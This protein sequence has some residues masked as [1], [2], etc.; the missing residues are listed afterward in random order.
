MSW[1]ERVIAEWDASGEMSANQIAKGSDI[2]SRLVASL[3]R[4]RWDLFWTQ[5]F[6]VP[7]PNAWAVRNLWCRALTEVSPNLSGSSHS[8]AGSC[9]SSHV[10][11]ALYALEPHN[12]YPSLHVHSLLSLKRPISVTSFRH[13]W[14]SWKNWSWATM[15]KALWLQC[16]HATPVWYVTKYVLKGAR[17]KKWMTDHQ[18]RQLEECR[19]GMLT[20]DCLTGSIQ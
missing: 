12:D 20:R 13:A 18:T 4:I 11:A 17:P 5:T 2:S 9:C 16:N 1:A 8:R 14:R 7:K 3:S 19:W 10:T 6:R 15:G